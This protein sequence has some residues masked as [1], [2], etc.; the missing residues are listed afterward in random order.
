[1]GG[2][3]YSGMS[4]EEVISSVREGYRMPKPPQCSEE[5]YTIMLSCWNAEPKKRPDFTELAAK[6]D[7]LVGDGKIHIDVDA[8]EQIDI[9]A[10][11]SDGGETC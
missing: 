11:Q 4:T 3:P 9:H 2:K 10:L 6:L 7:K 5:L 1:M 8:V